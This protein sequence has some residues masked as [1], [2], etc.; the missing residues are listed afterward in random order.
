MSLSFLKKITTLA[1]V[2]VIAAGSL[3]GV[4]TYAQS[5]NVTANLTVTAGALT[6]TA[7]ASAP[8]TCT[9][10][11]TVSTTTQTAAGNITNAQVTDLRGS[12][13]PWSVVMTATNFANTPTNTSFINLCAATGTCATTSRL[14]VTPAAI[15]NVSGQTFTG[16]DN[17]SSQNVTTLTAIG[18]A[19][20]VSNNFS[21]GSATAGGNQG[22]Y[23]KNI[24]LS[25]TLPAFTANATYNSTMV[26]TV[27]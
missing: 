16:T 17:T 27:S 14:T 4:N 3:S 12:N 13:L 11:C 2:A 21:I 7:D 5:A 1:G 20:G 9:P 26:L 25:L 23:R 22:V 19:T 18:N 6:I 8:L 15:T 24:G 10:A